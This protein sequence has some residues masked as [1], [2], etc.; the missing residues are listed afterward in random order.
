MPQFDLAIILL[1]AGDKGRRSPAGVSGVGRRLCLLSHLARSVGACR[2]QACA[3][4]ESGHGLLPAAGDDAAPTPAA[5]GLKFD[6]L[7]I[8]S[9]SS[10]G[11]QS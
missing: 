2:P 4:A 8:E 5:A 1:V 6:C 9:E 7:V 3:A 10:A 11:Q